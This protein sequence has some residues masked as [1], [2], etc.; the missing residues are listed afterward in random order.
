MPDYEIPRRFFSHAFKRAALERVLLEG[1][2][3][4]AVARELA[5]PLQVLQ[6]WLDAEEAMHTPPIVMPLPAVGRRAGSTAS[7][8]GAALGNTFE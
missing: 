6:Q 5:M 7:L 3:P 4:E 1:K 2:E 8:S